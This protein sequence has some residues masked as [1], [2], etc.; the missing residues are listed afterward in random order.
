[1]DENQI[2]YS[3]KECGRFVRCG[4]YSCK[5]CMLHTLIQNTNCQNGMH[6]CQFAFQAQL[7]YLHSRSLVC[8]K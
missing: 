4:V 6:M 3:I 1:M 8:V 7:C 2:K 5:Q